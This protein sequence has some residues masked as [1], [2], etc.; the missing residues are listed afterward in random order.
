VRN[1]NGNDK[2]EKEIKCVSRNDLNLKT[3]RD[4]RT[5][6]KVQKSLKK[7]DDTHKPDYPI[8]GVWP[9]LTTISLFG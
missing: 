9:L 5:K 7:K 1:P 8:T 6:K 2:T 3:K 4:D